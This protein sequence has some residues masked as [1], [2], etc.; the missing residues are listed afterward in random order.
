MKLLRQLRA[1]FHK[2]ALDREMSDEM[3]AHVEIQTDKNVAAG[4][5]PDEA[6]F[7]ALRKFGGVEQIKEQTRDI[8][9]LPWLEALGRDLRFSFRSLR[10][11][12]AFSAAVILTLALC[13]GANT[14]IF[15]VLYGLV[16]KPL[17]FR[18][19]GQ[20]V[21]V[22][23]MRPKAGEMHTTLSP[24][25][26]VDYKA[27]ADLFE[28]F[29][30]WFGWMF[31]I[32]EDGGTSRYV[33]MQVTYDYFSVLGL[34]PLLGRFFTPDDAV[35]GKD[36]VV[37]L[38]QS[39]WEK[40]FNADPAIVGKE[41]R[42][43]G[44]VFTVVGVVPR[45]F[46]ELSVAPLLM[47]PI[48]WQPNDLNPQNRLRRAG[49][50]TARIK[51][52]VSHRAALAQLETLEK[53]YFDTMA[54]PEL[55]TYL[56]NGGHRMGLVQLREGTTEKIRGGLLLL[57]A[58]ALLVLLLGCVNVA[59]LMLARANARYAEF[60]VRTTLGASRR[61]LARQLLT[62]AALLAGAGAALGLT[63]TAASLK[64]INVY[65]DKIIY[66]IPP[67][68]LD[69][70]VLG[71]T[72]LIVFGV[73]LLIGLLPV[74]RI[75]RMGSL[76]QAMQGG[77]RGASRG[78]GVRAMSGV[79]VVA[80]VALALMLLI[81]AGLL[82]RSFANVMAIN[83]GFDPRQVIHARVAYDA[84][85][86][87]DAAF[88][89]L[90]NR[91]L[92]KMRQIPGVES[93][94]YTD[95]MPGYAE[96]VTMALP[97]KGRTVSDE[98]MAPTAI[99]FGASP[100]YFGTMGIRLIEGRPFTAG[101]QVTG[102]PMTLIV[103]RKFAERYFPGESAVGQ[104]FLFGPGTTDPSKPLPT[105]VGVVEVARV[106]GLE[107]PEGLPYVYFSV[108]VS[109]GGLSIE[110]RTKRSFSE[111]MPLIRAAVREVD[112]ALPIYQE[113]TMQMQLDDAAANRRG[114]LWLLGAFAGIA[115]LLSAVG[116]YGM[117]AYD[118][119]QRTKEIGIRG[120]I[121]ATREQI[122]ALILKQG[123]V[124]AGL[125]LVLGL[126]GALALS[127]FLEK[128]LYDVKP[129]DPTVFVGVASLLLL[130]ALLASW[131]PARRAANVDPLVALRHE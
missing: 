18:D 42:L 41:L 63:L 107:N 97:I 47:K 68:K 69:A 40:K 109:R 49:D 74:L 35:P 34:K 48:A 14:S 122:V 27:N 66:G 65:T 96:N 85:F 58:G 86:K 87:D 73:A 44:Q 57:Q 38:T 10:R 125:G 61:V 23:N 131:L 102:M 75:W 130:V 29:A 11:S 110:L 55:R 89:A 88:R 90:Q 115:L 20:I 12:P 46:E 5:T 111:I 118:V 32:G 81:G 17:P 3:R 78:G 105:I 99:V 91:L 60:A 53:R 72:L 8:R 67:V 127:R 24:A 1:V 79:L 95:R 82:M 117:L 116:I 124:K 113:R 77:S 52:G 30:L 126:A 50:M 94:A 62:E 31:N 104:H 93:V 64:V 56:T 26:Y 92:E 106:S 71:A 37:V 59:S 25:Q 108:S 101:D 45:R 33:G 112:P 103:D 13:I 43:S 83:P 4:M 19:A 6:R 39:F 7:A 128:L 22:Y 70:G 98:S 2:D 119:T 21:D 9:G 16:L 123:L 76:N 15:S 84:R 36:Q 51:P 54:N 80:Q 114:I 28:G 100:E 121:G 120:A 129:T